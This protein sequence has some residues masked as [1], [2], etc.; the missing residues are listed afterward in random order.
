MT[1][2]IGDLR[3]REFLLKTFREQKPEIVFH[4]AAQPLVKKSYKDP[5]LTFETNVLGVV[6]LMEAARATDSVKVIVNVTSDKCYDN[7]IAL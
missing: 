5:A 7:V 1:S 3:D 2:V 6:N 4:L